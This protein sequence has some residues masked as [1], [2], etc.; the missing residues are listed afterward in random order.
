[1]Y[2]PVE[3]AEVD[4]KLIWPV[5]MGLRNHKF[6][7][8]IPD[9]YFQRGRTWNNKVSKVLKDTIL[10]NVRSVYLDV[11]Q[12][13]SKDSVH[14]SEIKQWI[15]NEIDWEFRFY[16]VVYLN[17]LYSSGNSICFAYARISSVL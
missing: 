13:C 4:A 11:L 3:Y 5:D 12:R 16:V 7:S 15:S 6:I 17:L 9:F 2:V 10:F 14:F 8:T 1:M